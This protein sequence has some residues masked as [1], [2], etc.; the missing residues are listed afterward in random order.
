MDNCTFVIFGATGDLTKR[1]LIPA[2]YQLVAEKKLT[3]FAIVGAAIDDV[4]AAAMLS[5]AREF[6]NPVDENVW[7]QL[8]AATYYQ[9][10][11][12]L[13]ESD[14]VQLKKCVQEAEKKHK[15]DGNRMLYC[16]SAAEFF[17]PITT[18]AV[19]SGLAKKTAPD[20]KPWCRLVYEKPFGHDLASAQEINECIAQRLDESQVYRIDHYLTKEVV[21]NIALIR[22]TNC[23]F[24]PLWNN[25]YIDQVQI[26]L[27]EK[28]G[29]E[30]RG[31]YYDKYGALA[32]V[33]Q[34]HM[35]ELLSLVGMEAPELLR[36]DYVQEQRA[37]VLQKIEVVDCVLGQY[38]G[39]LQEAGVAP[40]SQ[41]ETFA[42]LMLR[43]NNP[44]WAGVP[45]YLKTG[46]GLDKKE[47]V[48]HIKFKQVD[49]LLAK[50]CPSD[51]N[52][53][54]IKV[55]PDASFVLNLNAKKPGYTNDLVQVSMEY[56]HSCI[57]GQRSAEAYEIVFEEVIRGEL[58]AAVRFDEI[59]YAWKVIEAIRKDHFALN[60]YKQGTV[61]PE[62]AL[63]E[64][65]RKHGMRWRS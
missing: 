25:R 48:I 11:D 9:R 31:Y 5:R 17:C 27:S 32:D 16:A 41:T 39:Y 43:V 8:E 26:I 10:V 22:F 59:E 64:F 21:S 54:T 47:I 14:Y 57:F 20:A 65:S 51:S 37:K 15:L 46:K 56:C 6:I 28:E 60:P 55:T 62:E 29:I 4:T 45:F 7:K 40:R 52:W 19:S 23:V 34:N 50:N 1:K 38:D 53:L 2:L 49:C 18:H 33:V 36:G 13:N 58:A 63:Q 24:E 35:L 3:N 12:F 30:G 61:G 44:R 42:A